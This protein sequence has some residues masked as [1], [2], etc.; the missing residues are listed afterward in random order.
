MLLDGR[1]FAV[2][3]EGPLDDGADPR[4]PASPVLTE[5]LATPAAGPAI[6]GVGSAGRSH[7]SASI[8]RHPRGDDTLVFE[9]ACR[10]QEPPIRL[11]STYRTGED[12]AEL[13]QIAADPGAGG[14]PRTIAWRYTI[15][16]QGIRSGDAAAR[17]T[18]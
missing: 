3:V 17:P 13:V 14:L 12:S 1:I 4:W 18:N 5:V 11:G 8:T 2:S 7:F 9:I 15:G 10:I 6:V 16:P